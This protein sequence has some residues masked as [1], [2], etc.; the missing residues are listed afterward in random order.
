MIEINL[1]P[2]RIY[3][4][5]TISSVDMYLYKLMS[6][7]FVFA[8]IPST[9]NQDLRRLLL[10]HKRS[11][12]RAVRPRRTVRTYGPVYGRGYQVSVLSILFC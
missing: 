2:D 1:L 3:V 12:R 5:G 6:L 9:E 4:F 7:M 10:L 8:E 11:A